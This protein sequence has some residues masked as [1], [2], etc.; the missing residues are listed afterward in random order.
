MSGDIVKIQA[1]HWSATQL[2]L[3][4]LN[5]KMA[6]LAPLILEAAEQLD[7]DSSSYDASQRQA[8]AQRLKAALCAD[9][10][11]SMA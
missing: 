5:E 6:D 9:E 10:P 1:E 4:A 8:L 2:K 7:P 3:K 11:D